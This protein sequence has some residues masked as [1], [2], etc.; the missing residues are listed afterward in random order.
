MAMNSLLIPLME[1]LFKPKKSFA[2]FLLRLVGIR[3]RIDAALGFFL[4]STI[5]NVSNQRCSAGIMCGTEQSA[6]SAPHRGREKMTKG[7][8][9]M[10]S[11]V[12]IFQQKHPWVEGGKVIRKVERENG[13]IFHRFLIMQRCVQNGPLILHFNISAFFSNEEFFDVFFNIVST[14][15]NTPGGSRDHLSQLKLLALTISAQLFTV[16]NHIT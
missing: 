1:H 16:C 7:A 5:I 12:S 14:Q 13:E 11:D 9:E 15:I 3:I 8:R 6:Q 2:V 4:T 10:Q